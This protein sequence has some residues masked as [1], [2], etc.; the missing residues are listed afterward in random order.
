[1]T[2]AE[3]T[4]KYLISKYFPSDK[5]SDQ[6]VVFARKAITQ[7]ISNK[8]DYAGR[9]LLELLQNMDDA[10]LEDKDITKHTDWIAK[11][12]LEANNIKILNNGAPFDRDAMNSISMGNASAKIKNKKTT[13]SKGVG[14]RGVLNWSEDIRIYSGGVKVR[15]SAEGRDKV[16]KQLQ[17]ENN[18]IY[19]QLIK[20]FPEIPGQYSPMFAPFDIETEHVFND[21]FDTC[22][23]LQLDAYHIDAVQQAI[24]T[25]LEKEIYSILFMKRINKIIFVDKT[26]SGTQINEIS[27]STDKNTKTIT[28]H[29]ADG[30]TEYK[31]F[32]IFN[33]DEETIAIPYEWDKTAQYC[34]YHV[35]PITKEAALF[36]VLMNSMRF[37]LTNNRDALVDNEE[38]NKEALCSLIKLLLNISTQYFTKPQ[39]GNQA[40]E[41][42]THFSDSATLSNLW[43]MAIKETNL[44]DALKTAKIIPTLNNTFVAYNSNI[45][46]LENR[47]T[48]PDC[49]LKTLESQYADRTTSDAVKESYIKNSLGQASAE[50]LCN[51]INTLSSQWNSLQRVQVFK[52][53]TSIYTNSPFLPK[54]LKTQRGTFFELSETNHLFLYSGNNIPP[55]PTWSKIDIIDTLDRDYLF[56]ETPDDP[57]ERNKERVINRSCP[58][59]CTHG[60]FRTTDKN[61]IIDQINQSARTSYDNAIEFTRFIF[62]AYKSEPQLRQRP[63]I[64]Y[65]PGTD[66][67]THAAQELYFDE[68]YYTDDII[69]PKICRAAG[70]IAIPSPKEI[71]ILPNEIPDFVRTMKTLCGIHTEIVPEYKT[72]TEISPA[73]RDIL[74]NAI[75]ESGAPDR[76]YVIQSAHLQTIDKLTHILTNKELS[77]EILLKWLASIIYHRQGSV[78]TVSYHWKNSG[79]HTMNNPSV[80]NYIIWQILNTSWLLDRNNEKI[81]PCNCILRDDSFPEFIPQ[82]P[83]KNPFWKEIGIKSNIAELDANIFYNI[84]KMLPE[85]DTK[86][87]ISESIYAFIAKNSNTDKISHLHGFNRAKHDFIQNGKLWAKKKAQKTS[88]FYD[89]KDVFFYSGKVINPN[90]AILVTPLK[91]GNADVFKDIF[92]IE[93]FKENVRAKNATPHKNNACFVKEFN[94]FKKYLYLEEATTDLRTALPKLSI[95]LASNV[96]TNANNDIL[97]CPDY[98]VIPHNDAHKY[99]ITLEQQSTP[100]NTK[101]AQAIADICTKEAKSDKLEDIIAFL[102]LCP[103]NERTD[104][105]NNKGFN[106]SFLSKHVDLK[107]EFMKA[108]QTIN[109]DN[110]CFDSEVMAIKFDDLNA[111]ENMPYIDKILNALNTDLAAFN[112]DN[113]L[114]DFRPYNRTKL[115]KFITKNEN[116]ILSLLYAELR[117]TNDI[118]K[119]EIFYTH[120][121]NKFK[122]LYSIAPNMLPNSCKFNPEN[123]FQETLNLSNDFMDKLHNQIDT[124]FNVDAIYTKH[125][126]HLS[127]NI[128]TNCEDE[129]LSEFMSSNT[130]KGLLLFE[131]YEILKNKYDKYCDQV[132]NSESDDRNQF[133]IN[134][135]TATTI[136]TTTKIHAL[137]DDTHDNKGPSNHRNNSVTHDFKRN[138]T[139]QRN[140]DS[141][142]KKVYDMLSQNH[143]V[144]WVSSAAERHKARG[145]LDAVDGDS[146]GYD[147]LY[148]ENGV[149]KYVEVKSATRVG[150]DKFSFMMSKNEE[151]CARDNLDNYFVYLVIDNTLHPI[152]GQILLD[153]FDKAKIE[154]TKIC[155]IQLEKDSA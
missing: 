86:G 37:K 9:V 120:I 16:L 31:K 1:M 66:K 49:L 47:K 55:V 100:N 48:I 5:Q 60:I 112:N 76:Y 110:L 124:K 43:D 83:N 89:V 51:T 33:S 126:E 26:G 68:S 6:D 28:K 70:Y 106:T 143:E 154:T 137:S 108:V 32:Y 85:K 41:L 141:A 90:V 122:S 155:N 45:K 13:G 131:H 42:F 69:A 95:E 115:H 152:T 19:N 103:D 77:Q 2:W 62:E 145:S 71:G 117:R 104:F 80:P 84:L 111:P 132:R 87:K 57:N 94:R 121:V 18:Y 7:E 44:T 118:S 12:I 72:I 153:C 14:F 52:Y 148:T 38:T 35:F 75:R 50:E 113:L 17:E 149:K 88:S 64:L 130:N 136:D 10:A 146:A 82:T 15:F 78:N 135:G 127:K 133:N 128:L 73:Y 140:G 25:F 36:P 53:W 21:N 81:K 23:E 129:F 102:W 40:I 114:I 144:H 4:R 109:H 96:F 92:G 67:K 54:L 3:E 24:Q 142:E 101:L 105:L 116:E 79:I 29:N 39:F 30:S 107:E 147:M 22:I 93:H 27:V 123:Y 58:N 151:N 91:N 134:E 98:A 46:F 97:D 56:K 74:I 34:M 65:L 138:D 20:E 150:K 125:K 8:D 59:P 139:R 61:Q 11:F 99:F 119:H 63:E